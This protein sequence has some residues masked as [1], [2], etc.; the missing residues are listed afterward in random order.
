[1]SGNLHS[2]IVLDGTEEPSILWM[3]DHIYSSEEWKPELQLQKLKARGSIYARHYSTL[4]DKYFGA[5]MNDE[6]RRC[7]WKAFKYSPR[8]LLAS[9]AARRLAATVFGRGPY[10]RLKGLWRDA[11]GQ[12]TGMP[13]RTA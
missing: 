2:K 10:E 7:Y 11:S 3:L 8:Y 12:S 1:H 4:A 13:S 9:G 6:A 5:F